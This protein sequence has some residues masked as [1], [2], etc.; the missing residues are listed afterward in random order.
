MLT[1]KAQFPVSGRI[2]SIIPFLPFS[3]EEQA[4]I[5]CKYFSG[6]NSRL[7]RL[8]DT[9]SEQFVGRVN[10]QT[11]NEMSVCS[12][13]TNIYCNRDK[14]AIHAVEVVEEETKSEFIRD[15]LE[16]NQMTDFQ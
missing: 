10:L 2:S 5:D 8:I 3:L 9:H 12:R 16:A 14:G 13:I 7:Y 4:V 6:L 11:V 15:Y 1:F